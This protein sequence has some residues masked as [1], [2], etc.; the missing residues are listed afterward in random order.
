MHDD[1]QVM[2]VNQMT[3][4]L[5]DFQIPCRWV[6]DMGFG[7]GYPQYH[8]YGPLP[9]YLMGVTN[10]LKVDLFSSVKMG[11]ILSLLLGNIFMFYLASYLWGNKAG[12]LSSI[13]YAYLPYRA[14]DL[15]SR[16]AMA[17]SWAFVFLPLIIWTTLRFLDSPSI[18]KMVTTGIA[19]SLLLLS[20]NV[21]T[22]TF[23]PLYLIF[24]Y[25]SAKFRGWETKKILKYLSIILFYAVGLSAFFFLPAYLEK[26]LAHTESLTIGYFNYL[27]H[28]VSLKQLLFTSFW[29]YG[30]SEI[31]PTDDLSFFI[32]PV[33]LLLFGLAVFKSAKNHRSDNLNSKLIWIFSLLFLFSLFMTHQKSSFIWQI[34][35]F[36]KYLQFPWR[37]LVPATFFMSLAIGYVFFKARNS[38]LLLSIMILLFLFNK[39][40]FRPLHYVDITPTEKMTGH[41]YDKELTISIFD[42]LPKVAPLPPTQAVPLGPIFVNGIAALSNLQKSSASYS[43]DLIAS[44]PGQIAFPIYNFKGWRVKLD[45]IDQKISNYSNLGLISVSFPQGSHYL[46]AKFESTPLRSLANTI[47]L[48]F[49]FISIY[50]FK[51]QKYE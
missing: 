3:K 12:L 45:G 35:P 44:Q 23:G 22:L 19:F 16:G 13:A 47:S 40:Y 33:H 36:L 29:G 17:E 2:R 34:F 10:L 1:L 31:G 20:H 6:P 27:A 14:S 25:L 7:Y 9:Y 51:N 18:K 32:G 39:S 41:Y 48:I 21:T 5:K 49:I 8:Y 46:A 28:F 11:F 26:N 15:F 4:C 38:P 42:Y 30:S 37:Y 43:F 50:L 24:F